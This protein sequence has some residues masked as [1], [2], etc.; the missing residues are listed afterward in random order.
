MCMNEGD[1]IKAEETDTA[2]KGGEAEG[3]RRE[4]AIKFTLSRQGRIV[5][6]DTHIF[7]ISA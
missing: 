1:G 6:K 4:A 2:T 5:G 3:R 7:P